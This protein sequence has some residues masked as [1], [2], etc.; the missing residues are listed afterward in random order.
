MPICARRG[1]A[2]IWPSP[3]FGIRPSNDVQLSIGYE[4][5]KI[6]CRMVNKKK[7]EPPVPSTLPPPPPPS[8]STTIEIEEQSTDTSWLNQTR[9]N[10]GQINANNFN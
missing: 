5:E 9:T 2:I 10:M 7:I 6:V 3:R 1:E 4:S 8:T